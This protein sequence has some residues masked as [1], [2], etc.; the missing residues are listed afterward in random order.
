MAAPQPDQIDLVAVM[1]LDLRATS[2]AQKRCIASAQASAEEYRVGRDPRS[3]DDI[4]DALAKAAEQARVL[5]D[6]L[7]EVRKVLRGVGGG[8]VD[9]T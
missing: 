2:D 3:L 7:V 6:G 4:G 9:A 8:V 1:L 5:A